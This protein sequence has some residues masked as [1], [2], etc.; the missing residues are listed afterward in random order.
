MRLDNKVVIVTGAAGCIGKA[1]A[2]AMAMQGAKL[3]LADCDMDLLLAASDGISRE[4]CLLVAGDVAT[5]QGNIRMVEAAMSR[6]GKIDG[7]FANAGIEGTAVPMGEYTDEAFDRVF[8]VNVKSVFLGLKHVLPKMK[9]GSSVVLTS[10]IAGLIA[11]PR[12]IAYSA[13]KHAVV[14]LM[15]SAASEA[16]MRGI[17]VNS[18]HP[19]LVESPMVRRIFAQHPDPVAI[20]AQWLSRIKLSKFVQPL[21]I[22][23]AVIFLISDASQM[24]TSQTMV[25]DGGTIN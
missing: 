20:E 2:K 4:Q 10:S 11:A 18:V 5:S 14:G 24:I 23:Q 1:T 9:D 22:A 21:D 16:S 6:F 15:R 7:F 13:S 8:S 3:V 19:G 25:I 12:N 17:R